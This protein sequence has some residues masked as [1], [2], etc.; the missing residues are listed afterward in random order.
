MLNRLYAQVLGLLNRLYA[1][2]LGLLNR[3]YAQVLGL[4]QKWH[5]RHPPSTWTEL[6]A[7]R[8]RARALPMFREG[9]IPPERDRDVSQDDSGFKDVAR[10]LFRSWPYIRPQLLGRWWYPGRGTDEEV[11]DLVSGDGYQF[12]YA[13]FFVA[14]V[15]ALGPITGWVPATFDWPIYLLHG[16]VVAMVGAMFA[17]AFAQGRIQLIGTGVLV[18][19]GIGTNV[20]A[21]F[22][23]DGYASSLYGAAVTVSCI[24]GWMLQFRL[25]EGRIEYRVRVGAHVVYF[26]AINFTQRFIALALGVI[27]ADL[28]NQNLLQAEPL[29][30]ALANLFGLPEWTQAYVGELTDE[31]RR[32]LVWIYVYLALGSHLVQLPLRII[33]P[34]YHMWIMQ[35]INQDLRVAL[36]S[37]WHQLSLSYHSEHR[38]GDAIFRIYQDSA[39]VTAV[40]GHLINMTL[41]LMSYYSC[42]A[43]V[44]LL[45][46]WLGLAA[47]VLVVPA[48]LWAQ[49]AMPRMRTRTLVYRAATSDVTS[50]IQEGFGGIRLVK[51][52]GTAGRL[53]RRLEEDSVVAFNAAFRVRHL[54]AI[55]TIVMYS[56][57]AMFVAGSS[58]F[59]AWW[60][61][62]GEPAWALELIRLVGISFVAWNL[63]SF[64]WTRDQ[65]H[66]ATG[67]I[68]LLLRDWMTAQD[69]AMGLRRVF[70]ILDIEPDVQ[71]RSDAV[72]MTAFEREIRFEH[73]GFAYESDRPV[74]EGVSFA[75]RPG[76][77]TA[78]IGPTGSGKSTLMAL[79]LRLFDPNFGTIT[80]DGKPLDAYLVDSL[81]ANIAIA[82]QENVLFAMS[83]RDNI[84]YAAPGADDERVREAVRVA[85]MDDYVAGLPDGLDTVL[86]DRGGKLSSGQ[87]QRLSIA[88]A[89]V[90]DTPILVLD[91]PTAA[92]D[93]ATE[94][95][96][97]QRLAQWGE[98]RAIFL[99]THRISTIRRA[100]NIV[101]LDGGRIVESGD[102]EALMAR[103]DGRYRAFVEAESTLIDTARSLREG[104]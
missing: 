8:Q 6:E 81:R 26:Y 50:T 19:A 53:Q 88:R 36:I 22:F 3:L 18:L 23:I 99:I 28:L 52:F 9:E 31:Q 38:T 35:R 104:V 69:M 47:G 49:W 78:I 25:R 76:S 60:A 62:Q 91:E 44:T 5:D 4:R 92:L 90:R 89:V 66:E 55:V 2:V 61:N 101:Y 15:A 83:V 46:P 34:Y 93:A 14:I 1:Q 29:S 80:I 100:D 12:G 97:M 41:A 10:L 58:S 56:V 13:P 75:A 16:P 77:I 32:E 48:L 11:A 70:D 95:R 98:G 33:N 85:A 43:L 94:H 59:M 17:M 82:L 67:D 7:N 65:F 103:E 27:L 71:D 37:R 79:L 39:M 73:V 20:S 86:S 74:L 54:I 102:H 64:S 45:S 63:A 57:A 72:P 51:A 24:A 87:R 84:R 96:V 68:R 42:V 21:N 30:P 40:I